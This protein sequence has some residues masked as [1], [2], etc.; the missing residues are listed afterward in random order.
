MPREACEEFVSAFDLQPDDSTGLY[1]INSSTHS[2]LQASNPSLHFT[3]RDRGSTK[4]EVNIALQ[5][6]SLDF[7]VY[8]PIYPQPTRY[9]SLKPVEN[10]ELAVFDHEGHTS[11]DLM[12]GLGSRSKNSIVSNDLLMRGKTRGRAIF[13]QDAIAVVALKTRQGFIGEPNECDGEQFTDSMPAQ[14][15]IEGCD[16]GYGENYT[17][18]GVAGNITVTYA[19]PD[20]N[21]TDPDGLGSSST[22]CTLPML[23]CND[24][25]TPKI[26]AY[27]FVDLEVSNPTGPRLPKE[28]SSGTDQG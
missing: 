12:R 13:Y 26:C 5:Y 7:V 6:K 14:G 22:T 16:S 11:L 9:F 10:G 17:L 3:L 1:L 15:F 19:F 20:N 21:G 25:P 28:S 23:G 27:G 24:K 18:S 2:K 8:P 4:D